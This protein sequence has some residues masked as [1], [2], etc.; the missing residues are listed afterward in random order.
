LQ[1]D[2]LAIVAAYQPIEIVCVDTGDKDEVIAL[3]VRALLHCFLFFFDL[4][5]CF[6]VYIRM[7]YQDLFRNF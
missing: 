1:D 4:L 3:K 7:K 2:E 6:R 5:H